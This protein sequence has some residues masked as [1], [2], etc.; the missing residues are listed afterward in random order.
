MT[1]VVQPTR[2]FVPVAVPDAVLR[3]FIEVL[4]C[5]LRA[6]TE[7]WLGAGTPPGSEVLRWE[8]VPPMFAFHDPDGD[9]LG[10][11]EA[12]GPR[13]CLDDVGRGSGLVA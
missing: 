2:M 13:W 10:Y 3:Y 1:I 11:L 9:Q 6:D 7:D 5:E 8:G 12:G 4:G